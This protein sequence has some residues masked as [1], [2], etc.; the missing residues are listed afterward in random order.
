MGQKHC[1]VYLPFGKILKEAPNCVARPAKALGG[2][3]SAAGHQYRNRQK[4]A[5]GKDLRNDVK[6]RLL[7]LI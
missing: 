1:A 4:E 2:M 6:D 7:S 3:I 5:N